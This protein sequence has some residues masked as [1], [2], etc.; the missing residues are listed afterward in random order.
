[1][2]GKTYFTQ[3]VAVVL[4]LALA[5]TGCNN[6]KEQAGTTTLLLENQEQ[7]ASYSIGLDIG[8]DI[9]SQKIGLDQDF[10]VQGLKDGLSGTKPLLT[11]EDAEAARTAFREKHQ[12]ALKKERAEAAKLNKAKGQEFL[13]QN[14]AKEGVVTL[15]SGLQY[16][17]LDPGNGVKPNPDDN[18][19]VHYRGSFIDGTEFE[20]SYDDETP[21]VF[22]VKGVIPGWTEALVLMNEGAK[23]ELYI[24]SELAYGEMGAGKMIGPNETLIF[25][26]ELLVVH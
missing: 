1:M 17:I 24:P 12:T 7:K 8:K 3:L 25:Q 6:E 21:S 13:A 20:N 2:M 9:A 11:E 5:L 16:K 15:E 26:V 14:G 19:K 18:V 10:L 4:F 22:P 23:W